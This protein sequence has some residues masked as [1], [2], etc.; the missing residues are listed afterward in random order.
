MVQAGVEWAEEALAHLET[1]RR[2]IAYTDPRAAD[3]V[4]RRLWMAAES[5]ALFPNRGR[6][7]VNGTRELPSIAPYIISYEVDDARVL[8]L[9]IRHGRQRPP[10]D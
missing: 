1:I 5:L 7:C 3:R 4:A 8:I 10:V 9:R 6:P 2:Y